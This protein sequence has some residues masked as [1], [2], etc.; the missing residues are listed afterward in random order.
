MDYR[1]QQVFVSHYNSSAASVF[2]TMIL[3]QPLADIA[4]LNV[5]CGGT[6]V[7]DVLGLSE[8][9]INLTRSVVELV[10]E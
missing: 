2:D 4:C 10:G 1:R 5:F 9:L 6:D 8:L 7:G 3:L